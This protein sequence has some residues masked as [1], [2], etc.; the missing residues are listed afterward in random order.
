M[1]ASASAPIEIVT[2][3]RFVKILEDVNAHVKNE[4]G[5]P[6]DVII[7]YI[8]SDGGAKLSIKISTHQ[9]IDIEYDGTKYKA[10]KGSHIAGVIKRVRDETLNHLNN[11]RAHSPS[12]AS[13]GSKGGA[14]KSRR[15]RTLK[16]RHTRRHK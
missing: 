12:K 10:L 3:S 6:K 15:C 11:P 13:V 2:K 16:K 7:E 5:S 8:W 9:S 1:A 4:Y 14:R